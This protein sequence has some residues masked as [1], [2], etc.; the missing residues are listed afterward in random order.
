[1][2]VY[3][4]KITGSAPDGIVQFSGSIKTAGALTAL[5]MANAS[6][7]H[8]PTTIPENYNSLLYG[9]ITIGKHTGSLT[10]SDGAAV[11]I[12]DLVDV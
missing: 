12:K 9:P 5:A 6:T 2:A 1:M 4:T 3:T 11:K 8:H 7:I 10:I